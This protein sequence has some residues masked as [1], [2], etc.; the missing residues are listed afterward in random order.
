MVHAQKRSASQ[1][2][3]AAF[4][5]ARQQ[6]VQFN[7][8]TRQAQASERQ[9]RAQRSAATTGGASADSGGITAA[10]DYFPA[11]ERPQMMFF[12]GYGMF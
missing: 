9:R 10:R 11:R 1:Q 3:Q 6:G 5:D 2:R 7:Q 4:N 12:G 8:T